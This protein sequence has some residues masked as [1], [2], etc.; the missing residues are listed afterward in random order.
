M[1]RKITFQ[2]LLVRLKEK[3]KQKSE[4]ANQISIPSGAIKSKSK[5]NCS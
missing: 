1:E 5:L 2:F 3:Q 4:K